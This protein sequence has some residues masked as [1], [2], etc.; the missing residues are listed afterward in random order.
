MSCAGNGYLSGNMLVAYPFEDG[1]VV[2]WVSSESSSS[3]SSSSRQ[4]SM[5][6]ICREAQLALQKC[7]VDA[8][9][10]VG[11]VSSGWPEIGDFSI[12]GDE[13]RFVVSAYGSE[14]MLS[15]HPSEEDFII[16]NGSAD[17]GH[18]VI[19]LSSEGIRDLSAFCSR[20]G[21]VPA[22][23]DFPPSQGS[24]SSSSGRD[25]NYFIGIC[26]RC[27]S[28]RHEGLSS[29]SVYDGWNPRESGPHFVL[30][31]DVS[32][33]PGNNMLLSDP[34]ENGIEIGAV[35]GAGLGVVS[36]G[37]SGRKAVD[38]PLKSPDGHTRIFND[39]C[40]DF[41]PGGFATIL[42]DG[43][44]RLS[45]QLV[46]HAKCTA[47]CTCEMYASIVNDRLAALATLI[48]KAKGDIDGLLADYESGVR[49]FNDRIARP[50]LSDISMSITGMPTGS[51][52]GSKLKDTSVKGR[53]G[54]CAFTAIVRNSSFATVTA[55]LLSLSG[56]DII[57]EATASWSSEDG[58]QLSKTSGSATGIV[59]QQF[60][61][62]PGRSLVVTFVSSR[63]GMSS[64][65]GSWKYNGSASVSLSYRTQAGLSGSLGT[66]SR[67]VEV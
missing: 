28:E 36:C 67:S 41:E 56:T 8:L 12:S 3:S 38:S 16:L 14:K 42:V 45:R 32:V 43:K 58:S 37:C 19:V 44:E 59:G 51:N 50:S 53:M 15:A 46:I 29:I 18:Y 7:F 52:L 33:I 5:D 1:Q 48:R 27:V 66:L 47:C 6:E 25:G 30:K 54:R 10:C 64:S 60:V 55:H 21:I 35:P 57:V 13:I 9:V 11:D 26:A 31:G 65:V 20:N 22:S 23:R 24:S 40:Y 61:L 4:K 49:K 2:E 34:D 39:T 17:F 63:S 62:Y